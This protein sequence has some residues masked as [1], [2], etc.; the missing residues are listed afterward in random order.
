MVFITLSY[1]CWF[2][3]GGWCD[4]YKLF[5]SVY[6]VTAHISMN[7]RTV[8]IP[9]SVQFISMVWLWR[10]YRPTYSGRSA[11]YKLLWLVE[12]GPFN[13]SK[14][15]SQFKQYC[16]LRFNYT[17]GGTLLQYKDLKIIC[18]VLSIRLSYEVGVHWST[19][20]CFNKQIFASLA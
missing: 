17:Q 1:Y 4:L 18:V 15:H 11:V 6:N 5:V 9:E 2:K 10:N 20:K 19:N 16:R 3:A 12:Q 13:Q 8:E 14:S 7:I